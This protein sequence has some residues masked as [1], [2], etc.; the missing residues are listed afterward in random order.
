ML[1][2][3][4][5]DETGLHSADIP[6]GVYDLFTDFWCGKDAGYMMRTI[7]KEQI[8]IMEDS[9]FTISP[10]E[11]TNRVPIQCFLPNGELMRVPTVKIMDTDSE[12]EYVDHGNIDRAYILNTI[13]L[14]G[15]DMIVTPILGDY[16]HYRPNS[17]SDLQRLTYGLPIFANKNGIE[18]INNGHP[19]YDF[20]SLIEMDERAITPFYPG[21]EAFS[22]TKK[23]KTGVYGNSCPINAIATYVDILDEDRRVTFSVCYI[24]RLGEIRTADF[25]TIDVEYKINGVK[26]NRNYNK[27]ASGLTYWGFKA[28]EEWIAEVTFNNSNIMVDN[29]SG[30]NITRITF[31]NRLE[32]R[33]APA[34]QMLHFKNTAG[35]ITDRFSTADEDILEFA[36]GDF[37]FLEN[38]SP[39][40]FE[41]KKPAVEVLYSPKD[42]DDWKEL[43]VYEVPELFKDPGFGYFYR[44]SLEDVTGKSETNWYDLKITLTD[45]SGNSQMQLISPA[46][47]IEGT[48]GGTGIQ[49]GSSSP[50]SIV[51]EDGYLKVLN[52]DPAQVVLYSNNGT[53]LRSSSDSA[54]L[55]VGDLALDVYVVNVVLSD[56]STLSSKITLK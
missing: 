44:G 39:K 24:G 34:L 51:V 30:K 2:L 3:N 18:F 17:Y 1:L 53:M 47:K 9:D 41:C 26:D 42:N 19:R 33:S 38:E 4:Y 48:G 16:K 32:D 29:L 54:L 31:D 36:A 5:D 56:G 46:F 20:Y 8:S 40:Y 55:A 27:N 6:P 12:L 50:I 13:V 37:N 21:Q 45:D 28:I 35:L 23:E 15:Y 11:A 14:N 25:S 52:A 22:Y 10:C 43:K 49:E 7:I